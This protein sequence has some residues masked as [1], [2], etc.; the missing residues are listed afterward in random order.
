MLTHFFVIICLL[1][2]LKITFSILFIAS[3]ILGWLVFSANLLASLSRPVSPSPPSPPPSTPSCGRRR[4][5]LG[6]LVEA[7]FIIILTIL[8]LQSRQRTVSPSLLLEKCLHTRAL[9]CLGLDCFWS[10]CGL[11]IFGCSSVVS[12]HSWEW[13][14]DTN[15][16]EWNYT[17]NLTLIWSKLDELYILCSV[18]S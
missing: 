9:V 6:L 7:F 17:I 3:F 11:P 10:F 14:T 2:S 15:S 4:G 18:I 16:T 13:L 8:G 5:A 12:V 1:Y